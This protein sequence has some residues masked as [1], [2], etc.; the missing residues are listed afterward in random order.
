MRN[1]ATALALCAASLASS[2]WASDDVDI[3]VFQASSQALYAAD[4]RAAA[5]RAAVEALPPRLKNVP[6]GERAGAHIGAAGACAIEIPA[7][8]IEALSA[9]AVAEAILGKP[10][11]QVPPDGKAIAR[12]TLD[13]G[14]T[15]EAAE[16]ARK[17]QLRARNLA[18][19]ERDW[20]SRVRAQVKKIN[21]KAEPSDCRNLLA[22]VD[23]LLSRSRADGSLAKAE[24]VGIALEEIGKLRQT[25]AR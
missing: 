2:A 10:L 12:L 21:P 22:Q 1:L 7:A 8:D 24:G 17:R 23:D 13:V 25:T 3:A 16:A 20:V 4:E 18:Q 19:G 14:R 6:L 5:Q 9:L 11:A 15:A